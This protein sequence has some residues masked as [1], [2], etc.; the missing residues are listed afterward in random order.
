VR[1]LRLKARNGAGD[2]VLS[3]EGEID[4]AT[5]PELEAALEDALDP[6]RTR[7]IVDLR[8]VTFMDSTG[9]VLLLR[10]NRTAAAAG[11]R[12]I[13]IKGPPHVQRVFEITGLSERLTMLDEPSG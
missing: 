13:V 7:L 3:V 6:G 11:Q 5:A 4:F 8:R 10:H 9:L 12:L 2:M 1:G